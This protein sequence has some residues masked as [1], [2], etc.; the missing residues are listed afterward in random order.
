MEEE[1]STYAVKLPAFE[2]PLDLL[3]HLIKKDE[4]N[5][6]DIPIA[7]ITRQY[8]EYLDL[9]KSLNLNV[10]GDFLVM[11]AT[12]IHIKSKMLLPP[13]ESDEEEDE[14]DPRA[15]LVQRLLEYQQFK[16]VAGQLEQRESDWRE[17]F[18]RSPTNISGNQGD[19][20]EFSLSDVSLYDLLDVLKAI[21]DRIPEKHS[22]EILVDELSV[23]DQMDLIL[24]GLEDKESVTFPS[25]FEQNTSRMEVIVTFLAL[26]ELIRLK[27]IRAV[28]G[29][30][31]GVIRIWR[32]QS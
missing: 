16:G 15:D 1:T 18:H 13:A 23:Q 17:V 24:D 20:Q 32:I 26:L 9:I 3:L 4:I 25:L 2:G 27:V 30:L 29:E 8:L 5:I 12:L 11:A 6:Y 19:L 28:Q 21:F 14:V 31:F 7:S 10:V 22:L